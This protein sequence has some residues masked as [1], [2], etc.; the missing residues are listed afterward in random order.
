M[1]QSQFWAEVTPMLSMEVSSNNWSE[2]CAVLHFT[3]CLVMDIMPVLQWLRPH[4]FSVKWHA[5]TFTLCQKK[6]A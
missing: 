3:L 6:G 1:A 5:R 2:V 4:F